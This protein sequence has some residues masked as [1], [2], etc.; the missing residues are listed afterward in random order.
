MTRIGEYRDTLGPHLALI[1]VQI[2]F[3]TWPIAGK[4]VLRSMSTSSLV[5][6]RLTGAALAFALLQRKLTPLLKMP[7][8]DFLLLVL[9]SMLGVVGNQFLYVKGLALTTVINATLL[10]TT[11]PVFALFVS[12]LI[13]YDQ[14]SFR[15]LLG[16]VLAA[17][18][19]V[20]LVNPA[21]A[22]LSA[23][24]TAGNL[25]IVSNSLL[26]ATYIVISKTL[27]ERYGALNVITWIFLV[28]SVVTVPVGIYSL[29]QENLG[30]I[31]AGVWLLLLFIIIFPTVGAYY[32]NA[33]ALTKVAPS[34]VAIYI[35][36]Q[37]LVAFGFAPLLLG[38]QWNSRTI[39]A[40]LLIFMGVAVVTKRGR[41]RAIREISEHPDALAR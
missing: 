24:T 41:S 15:R 29:Q 9:C 7:A 23:Q 36:L 22:D 26:Y 28:G 16:I 18:G 37:P 1:A 2:L 40:A 8:K 32:L 31:S 33:W 3:G 38:E 13:G 11:I 20:Y 4:V 17:G 30:A 25:L 39:V 19:V 21:R 35:Y 14:L 10:S 34:T 12:I 27:L 5:S 6:C